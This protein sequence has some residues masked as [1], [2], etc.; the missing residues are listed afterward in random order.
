M[1]IRYRETLPS[2][3][4]DFPFLPGQVITIDQLSDQQ[5]QWVREGLIEVLPDP[6]DEDAML[7]A[8]A[9]SAVLPRPKGRGTR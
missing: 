2:D 8:P 7:D 1:R 6:S 5:E 3:Q 4:P 9:R